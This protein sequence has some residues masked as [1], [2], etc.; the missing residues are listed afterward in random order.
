MASFKKRNLK[1]LKKKL[2]FPFF[3]FSCREISSDV[4]TGFPIFFPLLNYPDFQ[5]GNWFILFSLYEISRTDK[6]ISNL[7]MDQMEMDFWF[8]G[9]WMK[10]RELLRW[11]LNFP[12]TFVD[13]NP[14]VFFMYEYM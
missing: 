14:C 12:I 11:I 3:V 13:R 8:L 4:N 1:L 2:F 7:R 5:Y 6:R 9:D 10:P